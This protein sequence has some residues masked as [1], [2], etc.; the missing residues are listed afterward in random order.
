MIDSL[1]ARGV[2]AVTVLALLLPV[3]TSAQDVVNSPYVASGATGSVHIYPTPAYSQQIGAQRG[4]VVAPGPALSY[5]CGPLM[6]GNNFYAI[7]WIPS[8]L[9]NGNPT[10]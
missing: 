4:P 2:L 9:Q 10:S 1:A 6:T 8:K 5:N 3:L 7:F